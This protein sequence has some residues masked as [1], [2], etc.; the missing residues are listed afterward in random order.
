MKRSYT[1]IK[2]QEKMILAL[3][4]SGKTRQEI[5]DGLGLT[6]S[7][8]KNWIS[9]H[10]R[11]ME[12]QSQGILPKRKGRPPKNISLETEVAQLR[13]ENELLRDFQQL[14]GRR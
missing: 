1:H 10:N 7:Q 11:Q 6:K 8:I 12:Q 13:M 9:R 5:A 2:H 4:E 14:A 3:R